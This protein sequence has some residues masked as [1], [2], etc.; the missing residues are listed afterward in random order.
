MNFCP[1]RDAQDYYIRLTSDDSGKL[2][3]AKSILIWT[4]ITAF[5][6]VWKLA[7]TGNLTIEF[8]SVFLAWGSGHTLTSKWLDTK[9]VADNK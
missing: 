2:S 9:S 7:V 6:V 8:F 4:A 1:I 3:L 5:I